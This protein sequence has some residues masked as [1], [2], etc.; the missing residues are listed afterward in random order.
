MLAARL[1]SRARLLSLTIASTDDSSSTSIAPP[2]REDSKTD[3]RRFDTLPPSDVL[4]AMDAPPPP[5]ELLGE[6]SG[7]SDEVA[8]AS[9]AAMLAQ[10]T[11]GPA[12][13]IEPRH[14]FPWAPEPDPGIPYQS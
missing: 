7:S 14:E 2:Q 13:A 3:L 6:Q 12:I 4:N 1:A 11:A 8:A 10:Q 9:A 5:S